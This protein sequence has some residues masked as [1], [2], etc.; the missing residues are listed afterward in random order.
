MRPAL[1]S[2]VPRT[3][4]TRTG[5][6]VFLICGTGRS[7]PEILADARRRLGND[8]ETERGEVRREPR[9]TVRLRLAKTFI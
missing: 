9:D 6:A 3:S 7:A 1:T 2:F 8:V 4:R 5:S